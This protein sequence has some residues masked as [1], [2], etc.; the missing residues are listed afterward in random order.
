M[1]LRVSVTMCA[2]T[3]PASKCHEQ[4]SKPVLFDTTPVHLCVWGGGDAGR[5]PGFPGF[6]GSSFTAVCLAVTSG[7]K[8]FL[9]NDWHLWPSVGEDLKRNIKKVLK[10]ILM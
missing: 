4:D 3:K 1:E 8:C 6:P 7:E 9:S 2:P 5:K 10:T